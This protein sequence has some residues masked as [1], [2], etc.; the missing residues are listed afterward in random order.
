MD[1]TEFDDLMRRLEQLQ[2]GLRC[3][4]RIMRMHDQPEWGIDFVRRASAVSEV[5]RVATARAEGDD[6]MAVSED[7]MLVMKVVLADVEVRLLW[8]KLGLKAWRP[9]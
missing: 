6:E 7:T 3:A 1:K 9:T 2:I 4:D 5:I 8:D